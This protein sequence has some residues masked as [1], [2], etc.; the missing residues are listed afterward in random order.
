[1]QQVGALFKQQPRA[2]SVA[3]F[4]ALYPVRCLTRHVPLLGVHNTS[5]A[6]AIW[7]GIDNIHL[8]VQLRPAGRACAR[9]TLFSSGHSPCS[10]SRA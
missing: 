6:R 10:A 5:A 7:S 4:S 2:A 8:Q 1:M 9:S 3:L